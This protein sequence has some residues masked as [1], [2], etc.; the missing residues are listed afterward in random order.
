MHRS[1][2]AATAALASAVTAQTGFNYGSTFTNGAAKSQQDF[3]ASFRQAKNLD[4]TD[5]QFTSARL[6][7]TIQPGSSN[8][9]I[10]A[11]PAAIAT[12]TRLLLGLW[13]SA[14]QTNIDNEIDALVS[15]VDQYGSAFVD[16]IDGISVG[17]EDLYRITPTGIANLAGI[18]ENPAVVADYINQAKRAISGTAA[19]SKQVGHVDTWTAWVNGSNQAV[20]DASDFIG[21]D[22]YPYFQTTIPNNID[23][24]GEV[25]FEALD[26]TRGAV[27]GKPLWV[28]ETGSPVSGPQSGQARASVE[29]AQSYWNQVACR[30]LGNQPTWWYT[31]QDALPDTPSPSFGVVGAGGGTS[32]LYDLSC[33]NTEP[34]A[35]SSIPISS[36]ASATG[37]GPAGGPSQ[38]EPT[39]GSGSGS[40]SDSDS[41][42]SDGSGGPLGEEIPPSAPSE[43]D[44]G[45]AP[46]PPSGGPSDDTGSYDG[47]GAGASTLLTVTTPGGEGPSA[48]PSR[49]TAAV[50]S[51]VGSQ[52]AGTAP[53]PEETGSNG[54]GK[55]CPANLNG[56]YEFPHLIVPVDSSHPQKAY[57]TSYNGQVGHTK[58]SIYNFDIPP[59][60]HDKTCTLVFLFPEKADLVT[61]S[62][63]ISGS[64]GLDVKGLKGPA[65]E[66]TSYGTRPAIA[67][68]VGAVD[69]ISLG[70]SYTIA[71]GPCAA[72][73]RIGYEVSATGG[74][75]LD[76]FQD[77]NPSPIGLYITV[78]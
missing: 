3:E 62:Y 30:L 24:A 51:S 68:D 59:S 38:A 28:T 76:Y 39:F 18:G 55:S 1:L 9:P 45:P 77:Y 21:M 75:E 53:A 57:G 2:L 63:T 43:D 33:S 12:N 74:L 36:A 32:P 70:N 48:P 11:I 19:S 6:F 7:T 46:S 66:Q 25:F 52:P 40:D 60:E 37:G 35:S 29:D 41:G 47:S 54:G 65:T 23:V 13:A 69:K 8:T 31:L 49:S 73:H 17:S 34:I 50:P 26:A 72:G 20:I 71:S 27:G 4:G 44:S 22:A 58:S 16:L 56:N 61:S 5:G 14:G 10:A 64:G 67:E 42:A 15:A 78:C